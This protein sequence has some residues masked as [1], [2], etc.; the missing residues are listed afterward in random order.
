MLEKKSTDHPPPPHAEPDSSQPM[1]QKTH[2]DMLKFFW[3]M[4]SK[5]GQSI[6]LLIGLSA[7]HYFVP[8]KGITVVKTQLAAVGKGQE[9][10]KK[11]LDAV[12]EGQ[13]EL[14]KQLNVVEKDVLVVKGGV[15]AV[16]GNTERVSAQLDA[17]MLKLVPGGK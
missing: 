10:L 16:K 15:T 14:K 13:G 8:N 2:E 12:A 11:Q 9:G 6:F 5:R 3:G 4:L 1:P 7:V 17:L